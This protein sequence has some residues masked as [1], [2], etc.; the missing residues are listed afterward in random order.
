MPL[1]I[2]DYLH[3][4]YGIRHGGFLRRYLEE[5]LRF[6]EGQVLE[7]YEGWLGRERVRMVNTRL[8]G[9]LDS[10]KIYLPRDDA[11]KYSIVPKTWIV[12]SVIRVGDPR[13]EVYYPVYPGKIVPYTPSKDIV[14]ARFEDLMLRVTGLSSYLAGFIYRGYSV[15]KEL[16]EAKK[17]R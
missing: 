17:K 14:L 16:K 3:E 13:K 6:V 12:Y 5:E 9:M 7:V 4:D 15:V 10:K 1:V 8:T 2:I 11:L